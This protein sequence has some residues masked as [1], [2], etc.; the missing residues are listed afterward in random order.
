MENKTKL[1]KKPWMYMD[2]IELQING[3]MEAYK[4]LQLKAMDEDNV[5]KVDQFTGSLIALE[6]LKNSL[7]IEVDDEYAE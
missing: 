1:G 4:K 2:D 6:C 5:R 3:L 7:G